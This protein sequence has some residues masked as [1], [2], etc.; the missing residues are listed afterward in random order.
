MKEEYKYFTI[1]KEV[2]DENM[3]NLYTKKRDFL[4]TLEKHNEKFVLVP[5]QDELDKE[6]IWYSD[7]LKDVCSILD[8]L[9][10]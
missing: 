8:E 3:Y 2:N 10:A 9:N 5:F 6:M 4:G 1:E 7:C